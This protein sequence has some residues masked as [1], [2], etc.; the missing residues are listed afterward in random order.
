MHAQSLRL[1]RG[2]SGAP[3]ALSYAAIRREA[4]TPMRARRAGLCACGRA[5]RSTGLGLVVRD[6]QIK[7]TQPERG[8][9]RCSRST[10]T[11][12]TTRRGAR[13]ARLSFG[14]GASRSTECIQVH[15]DST[16]SSLQE[17]DFPRRPARP[18]PPRPGSQRRAAHS[19][20]SRA[21]AS[22]RSMSMSA[23]LRK[24][25]T[26][27][28]PGTSWVQVTDSCSSSGSASRRRRRVSSCAR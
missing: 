12:A 20:D 21:A 24:L 19:F 15:K 8:E 22:C 18:C 10:G 11:A 16:R 4:T 5:A 1:W 28:A 7:L 26:Y 13:K 17:S 25:S 14:L 6:G 23:A 3:A 27:S 2:Q 9:R